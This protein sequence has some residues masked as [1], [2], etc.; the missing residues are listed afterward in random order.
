MSDLETC[1]HKT[2]TR[3]R[4]RTIANGAT[5]YRRQCLECG[6][7]VGNVVA[8]ATAFQETNGSPKAFDED[9]FKQARRSS[10]EQRI[11]NLEAQ[12]EEW[13]AWYNSYLDSDEWRR[14]R[15]LVIERCGGTCE[16][17]RS[18]PV[19]QV[20]HTTYKHVGRELLFELVGLCDACHEIAHAENPDEIPAALNQLEWE[21][22][23]RDENSDP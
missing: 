2:V 3:P 7:P 16:G 1:P 14:R 19:K 9:L 21:R 20:H 12:S 18:Q 17:C 4:A 11:R 22:R 6:E 13:F 8:K 15:A 23:W 10:Q 5:Q